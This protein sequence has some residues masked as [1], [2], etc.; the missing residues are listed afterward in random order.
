[1]QQT[2]IVG[3]SGGVDSSLSALLLKQAGYRVIGLFM[4][5]WEEEEHLGHCPATQDYEDALSVCHQIDIPLY[6][7]NF[8]EEYW[9]HVF[10]KCLKEYELGYTPNPDILCNREIKFKAFFNK[11]LELG[12]DLVATGHYCRTLLQGDTWILGRGLDPEKDQSYFLYTLKASILK[13]VIFP[14]GALSKKEVRKLAAQH[15]L[16]T[17][18]KKDSTGICFIGKRDFPTF[19]STYIRAEPGNFETPDGRVVGQHIG[20][21]FYT[22]GQ[23]RG[24]GI[25]GQGEA[26]YV[27]SKQ[28]E[29]NTIIVVQGENHPSLF[30]STLLA[31]D[32]TWV[33]QPPPF[34][35]KCTAKIRYRS[36]D[37][38]CTVNQLESGSLT[39]T[40]D[41]PQKAITPRQAIVFYAGPTCLGGALIAPF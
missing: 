33:G 23:R 16:P 17:S 20:I 15:A 39:V 1:M 6:S 41:Q 25:G 38:P 28:K 37:A 2:V 26:W 4:K 32:V 13:K 30:H 14:V 11:A 24:L 5:N 27:T 40:F 12:A 3:M 9:D 22:I 21:P 34:P 35:L 10:A 18:Q 31:T 7:V 19:L 36:P 29:R 8:V